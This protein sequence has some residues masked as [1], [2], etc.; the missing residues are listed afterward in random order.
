MF[1]KSLV[2]TVRTLFLGLRDWRIRA[3]RRGACAGRVGNAHVWLRVPVSLP[4]ISWWAGIHI[5]KTV[6]QN[7]SFW[8][9]KISDTVLHVFLSDKSNVFIVEVFQNLVRWHID[10][11]KKNLQKLVHVRASRA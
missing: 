7:R 3:G 10:I 1:S 11:L 4:Y 9:N 5:F 6:F 2:D 8:W